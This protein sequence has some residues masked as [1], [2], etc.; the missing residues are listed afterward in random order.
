MR[1]IGSKS[2]CVEKLLRLVCKEISSFSSLCDP[3]AGTCTVG[4]FFKAR[5]VRVITG[6]LLALSY[7]YQLSSIMLEEQPRFHRL[8]DDL[9]IDSADCAD[10]RVLTFLNSLPGR[11]GW[12]SRNFSLDGPCRRKYLTV[13]NARRV[14]AIRL[15]IRKW[16]RTGMISNAERW[17]LIACLIEALD[18]VANTAGTYYAHLRSFYRKA[19]QDI[20]LRPIQCEANGSQGKA[21]HGP[22]A[23][24][25]RRVKVDVL[26]LDP[27]YNKRDY[28]PYYHLPE[29]IAMDCTPP[30]AGRSGRPKIA[31]PR[32]GFCSPTSAAA[33]LQE[34][35]SLC[36]ARLIV[37]HYAEE[38]L[39]SH[40]AILEML[41]KKGPTRWE[42]WESRSYTSRPKQ[43]ERRFATRIYV[44][45][46]A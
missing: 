2:W 27:P 39:V 3:F 18:R 35:V 30:V 10:A 41:R 40:Q 16:S 1:Y 11:T 6:D 12:V 44:C 33:A 37:L 4:R 13:A 42:R 36:N 29:L 34:V 9:G 19:K 45:H 32:S 26:Y 23:A 8:R 5:G 43:P 28:G 38:G 20:D 24:L 7:A 14:D 31:L 21:F 46:A 15:A 22:A 25:V 17:Y